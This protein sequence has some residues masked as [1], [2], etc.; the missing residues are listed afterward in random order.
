MLAEASTCSLSPTYVG[1]RGWRYWYYKV[2]QTLE[3][4][5]ALLSYQFFL[6]NLNFWFGGV[7]LSMI[8]RVASRTKMF[9]RMLT[10]IHT[11]L[12]YPEQFTA[13]LNEIAEEHQA[14]NWFMVL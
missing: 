12:Y 9:S 4:A 7:Q 6:K 3:T 11:L 8:G 10:R 2:L 5:K 14:I 13:Q 1:R